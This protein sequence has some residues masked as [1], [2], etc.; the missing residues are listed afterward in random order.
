MDSRYVSPGLTVYKPKNDP[1]TELQV[2]KDDGTYIYYKTRVFNLNKFDGSWLGADDDGFDYV[3]HFSGADC[4]ECTE[5]RMEFSN[6]QI[7]TGPED[8]PSAYLSEEEKASCLPMK[9]SYNTLQ[10]QGC[11]LQDL[12]DTTEQ[13]F[14]EALTEKSLGYVQT[15]SKYPDTSQPYLMLG[16]D[17]EIDEVMN[18][19]SFVPG[20]VGRPQLRVQDQG[21]CGSCY[22]IGTT[23]FI[24]SSYLHQHPDEDPT[25]MFSYQQ[26]M[27]CLPLDRTVLDFADGTTATIDY[28]EDTGLGCWGGDGKS[29]YNWLVANGSRIPELQ[30]VPYIGFQGGCDYSVPSI[31]TGKFKYTLI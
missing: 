7:F 1:Y 27:N 26:A 9:P 22:S 3:N 31:E 13:L 10:C 11:M 17:A 30:T 14:Y 18:L 15:T 6:F 21:H 23:H 28:Y 20:M 24:T 8:V 19:K 12:A 4:T 5:V 16:S 25:F 2:R 29:I